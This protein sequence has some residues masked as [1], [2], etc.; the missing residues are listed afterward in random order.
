VGCEDVLERENWRDAPMSMI[1]N[2]R[3]VSDADGALLLANPSFI[4]PFL[5]GETLPLH[6]VP[7]WRRLF[8]KKPPALPSFDPAEDGAEL[9]L[10]KAWHGIHFLLTGDSWMADGGA[11]NP[12]GF[13]VSDGI[14]IGEVDVGYGPARFL[15]SDHVASVGA[16]LAHV[17]KKDIETRF[18]AADLEAAEIYPMIWDDSAEALRYLLSYFEELKSFVLKA[19]QGGKALVVYIN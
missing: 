1:S 7:F 12:L 14:E 17:N 6:D 2:L 10:D 19:K 11:A 3:M 9:Y 5:Y 16:A 15:S 8:Q 4:Q 13:L 18:V